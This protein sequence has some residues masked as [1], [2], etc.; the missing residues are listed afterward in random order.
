MDKVWGLIHFLLFVHLKNCLAK[1]S[2][3]DRNPQSRSRGFWQGFQRPTTTTQG[4]TLG[5]LGTALERGPGS[6]AQ[7]LR[8][9]G[10]QAGYGLWPSPGPRTEIC[11][12]ALSLFRLLSQRRGI[13]KFM[14][15]AQFLPVFR[16]LYTLE[17][18]ESVFRVSSLK[19]FWEENT[20]ELK[21]KT[22]EQ[23]L[24]VWGDLV[25]RAF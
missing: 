4:W 21:W 3:E 12:G 24:G 14:F 8:L 15:L 19:F 18:L 17:P 11:P 5:L 20:R 7:G 6:R 1:D 9:P 16:V 25:M 13:P 22:G 2:S 23:Q 10:P